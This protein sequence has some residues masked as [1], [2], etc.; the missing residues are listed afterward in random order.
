MNRGRLVWTAILALA[1][2]GCGGGDDDGPIVVADAAPRADARADAADL[3]CDPVAQDRCLDPMKPKCTLVD[4]GTMTTTLV[5]RCV[6]ATGAGMMMAGQTCTRTS[7]NETGY[8]HDDCA[9]GSWCSGVGVIPPMMGGSRVCRP[10][11]ENDATCATGERCLGLLD[12]PQ[13]GYCIRTCTMFDDA[14]CAMGLT[15]SS[16]A[17]D[18]DST[19]VFMHCRPT[20]TVGLGGVCSFEMPCAAGLD[21]L[22][23]TPMDGMDNPRCT[24]ICDSAHPCPMGQMCEDQPDLPSAGGYCAPI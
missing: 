1:L 18:V 23:L 13:V 24:S 4:D 16:L 5:T 9:P 2:G 11:C 19:Y 22:D 20:G 8:G 10:F 15:C 17:V 21:C 6:A 3:S 12:T 7:D 14:T